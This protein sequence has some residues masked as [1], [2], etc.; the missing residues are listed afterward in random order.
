MHKACRVPQCQIVGKAF[1]FVLFLLRLSARNEHEGAGEKYSL[2]LMAREA[3]AS[4]VEA[5]RAQ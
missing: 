2:G 1:A 4:C 5:E 3:I